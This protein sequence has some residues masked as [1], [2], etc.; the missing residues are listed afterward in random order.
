MLHFWE[1]TRI[2]DDPYIMVTLYGQFKGEIGSGGTAYPYQ[3]ARAA[4][5]LT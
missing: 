5:S 3:I 4:A 2:E 1:E